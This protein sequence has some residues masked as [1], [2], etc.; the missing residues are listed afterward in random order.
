MTAVLLARKYTSVDLWF[1]DEANGASSGAGA[2]C[3]FLVIPSLEMEWTDE[4]EI[5]S[6]YF[7]AT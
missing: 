2:A 1:A 3:V 7:L 6:W 5:M 4:N